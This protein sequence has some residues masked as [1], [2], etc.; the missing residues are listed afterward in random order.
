MDE[1]PY[2]VGEVARVAGVTVRTLHHY[3]EVGLLRPS[4]RSGSGRRLYNHTDLERLQRILAYRELGFGLHEIATVLDDARVDPLD[5]LRTQ[6][7][8]LTE[9][10]RRLDRMVALV[11]RAMEARAM[12]INLDPHEMF[13]VFGEH[14]PTEHAEE[15]RHRW[16]DTEAYKESARCSASL[17]KHDWKQV[18]AEGAATESRFA[19]AM[20]AG[21][22]ASSPEAMGAAEAHR[23]HISRWFYPC[24]YEMQLGLAAMYVDDPRFSAHYEQRAPGLARYVHDAIRANAHRAGAK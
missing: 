19:E 10:A 13:E 4:A 23:E 9:R 18:T 2:P 7:A 3:D 21:L 17:S 6:H 15:A 24:S 8:L 1:Q 11:E 14:D 22:P 5:H 12:G 20:T 16:G